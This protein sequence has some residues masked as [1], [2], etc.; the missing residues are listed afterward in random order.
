MTE[1]D[2]EYRLGRIDEALKNNDSQHGQIM[3]MLEKIDGDLT[4]FQVLT[5]SDISTM[6][7]KSAVWGTIAGGITAV[8][9][10]ILGLL[11]KLR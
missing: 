2:I 10:F 9:L 8:L 6:R 3:R 7:G 11:F 1:T 5:T 4:E